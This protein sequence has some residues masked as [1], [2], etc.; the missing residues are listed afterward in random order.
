MILGYPGQIKAGLTA[1]IDCNINATGCRFS[2]ILAKVDKKTGKVIKKNPE[3]IE[4]YDG[5]LVEFEPLAPMI[6]EEYSE[7]AAMGRFLIRD[8]RQT[9]GVGIVKKVWKHQ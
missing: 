7:L 2:K 1:V 3:Y 5:A 8:W 4:A 6:V 9:V